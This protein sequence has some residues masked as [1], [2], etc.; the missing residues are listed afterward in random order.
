MKHID[1]LVI[2]AGQNG[3]AMSREL[4]AYGIDH[5]VLDRGGIANSWRT[6]RWDSLKLLTPNWQSRMPGDPLEKS[7]PHGFMPIASLIARLDHFAHRNGVPLTRDTQVLTVQ[8]APIGYMVR[9]TRGAYTAR[10]VVMATGACATPA[11][12]HFA[13][14]IPANVAQFTPLT[15]KRPSQLRRGR[16]LVVGASASGVQIASELARAGRE[17]VLAVGGHVR[18][19]RFYRGKDIMS[20]LELIGSLDTDYTAV[21]DV[22]RVRRT[23]SMQL[24]GS[25]APISDL[26]ALQDMGVEITGRLMAVDSG[27]LLFSG[28]LA[29]VANAADLKMN[30]LLDAIDTWLL[31]TA[32]QDVTHAPRR[33]AKSHVPSS[34]RLELD[35][36]K[37]CVDGIVWCNGFRADFSYLE[38]PAAFDA[39]G[40]L[41]HDGGVI[42]DGLYVMGLPFL[43]RRRSTFIDGA[44]DDASDLAQHLAVALGARLAA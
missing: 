13:E 1:T 36:K 43:R 35:L 42:G 19:P 29:H 15:Y 3:L 20:W 10:A 34:P 17:V 12:P 44:G 14:T 38:V 22:D 8:S 33:F 5:L 18:V 11:I 9:T 40:R 39:R 21:D 25:R 27:R 4:S 41:Q 26:N 37:E 28:S 31:D 16:V 24:V 6:E 7:D 2:G 23:P 30:R 32:P